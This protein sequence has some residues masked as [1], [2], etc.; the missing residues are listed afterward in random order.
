VDESG[1]STPTSGVVPAT[2]N[3]G[4]RRTRSS[5]AD[6]SDGST[7][8]IRTGTTQRDDPSTG[9]TPSSGTDAERTR[10]AGGRRTWRGLAPTLRDI[11]R[12]TE[13]GSAKTFWHGSRRT[14]SAIGSWS[15]GG[16]ERIE[17]RILNGFAHAEPRS[18]IGGAPR[19]AEVAPRRSTP[20]RSTCATDDDAI[21]AGGSRN[22]QPGGIR[23]RSR[24]ITSCRLLVAGRTRRRTAR[25]RTFDA[26]WSRGRDGSGRARRR[27][28]S[29]SVVGPSS[30]REPRA[31]RNVNRSRA[32][33]SKER[34]PLASR[35]VLGT[36]T[37][38]EPRS[39]RS[40]K[41][42]RADEPPERRAGASRHAAG[43][44][45]HREPPTPRDVYESR[46][47]DRSERGRCASR[48]EG[49]TLARREPEE[50]RYVDQE[51]AARVEERQ[52]CASRSTR[53]ATKD[54]GPCDGRHEEK[55]RADRV[56]HVE[57]G[58]AEEVEER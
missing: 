25:R 44:C 47:R 56:R 50:T 36:P 30:Y 20:A 31:F 19:C 1:R 43:T 26:T 8:G 18:S 57:D 12:P 29:R 40:A 38:S 15:T 9:A 2:T 6:S 13:P 37:S 11:E 17:R 23:C 46:A 16:I 10:N 54:R 4:S 42:T 51:R 32:V 45:D 48:E 55:E 41:W 3:S 28:T 53:G 33:L 7:P 22:G 21:S 24:W 39:C 27:R 14:T 58:R 35:P 49:G 52:I 34:G 5:G